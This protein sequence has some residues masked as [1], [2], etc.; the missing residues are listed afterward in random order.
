MDI[1][2]GT[3]FSWQ[4]DLGNIRGGRAGNYGPLSE[5]KPRPTVISKPLRL[6]CLWEQKTGAPIFKSPTTLRLGNGQDY[7][8]IAFEFDRRFFSHLP[9]A[10]MPTFYV[11]TAG[12]R[13]LEFDQTKQVR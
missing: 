2:R 9:Q 13:N 8:R 3:P 6:T 4:P 7:G 12:S 11:N 10:L 5:W 1:V